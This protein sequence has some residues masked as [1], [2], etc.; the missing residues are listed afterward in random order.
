MPQQQAAGNQ[1]NDNALDF[2]WIIVMVVA[3]VVLIWVFGKKYIVQGLFFVKSYELLA[4]NYAL[5][6]YERLAH[7]THLP[8]PM[9]NMR[10]VNELAAYVHTSSDNVPVESLLNLCSA[11]GKY[12]RI[13]VAVMLSIMAF[14]VYRSNLASKF[15]RIFNM[16]RLKALDQKEWPQITPVMKVDLVD[17]DL[18]DGPWAMALTPLEFCKR[19]NLINISKENNQNQITL[20]QGAA[21]RVF[22]LQLGPIWN[23]KRLPIHVKALFAIFAAR[24]NRDRDNADK[25]LLQISASAMESGKLDFTG[26]E[27]LFNKHK[28]SKLAQRA[29]QKHGY[30]LTVMPS[31]LELARTDG[32]LA[33]AE[34][35]WLKPIDRKLWYIL[36]SV[37]R[38][39]A[40]PEIAGVFAHWNAEKMIKRPLQVPMVE[41]ASKAMEI[42]L[43]EIIFDSE[44]S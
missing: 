34:F 24:A 42:A 36:N 37:G 14:I 23:E 38:Q 21:H 40:I 35:L 41:E 25:L 16:Q 13:P 33:S 9:P 7:F 10:Y 44:E 22:A 4:I 6:G 20:L 17:T 30:M 12:L 15:K 5:L 3:A 31:M 27:E 1:A 26:A 18:N 29:V 43:K 11:V 19:N 32:V 39:T 8:L 28:N 2:L